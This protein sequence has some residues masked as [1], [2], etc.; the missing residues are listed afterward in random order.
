MTLFEM[1][2]E[3]DS[4]KLRKELREALVS[5]YRQHGASVVSEVIDEASDFIAWEEEQDRHHF[6]GEVWWR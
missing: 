6:M 1:W 4:Y 2:D 5:A 3:Y